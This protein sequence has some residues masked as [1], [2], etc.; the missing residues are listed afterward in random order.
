MPRG[1]AKTVLRLD[2]LGVLSQVVAALQSARLGM[3]SGSASIE[4]V[5]GGVSAAKQPTINLLES[6]RAHYASLGAAQFAQALEIAIATAQAERR[7]QPTVEVVWTGPAV[8]GSHVRQTRQVIQDMINGANSELLLVGYWVA[9]QRDGEGIIADVIS[10]VADAAERGVDVTVVL[11]RGE[12]D[13]GQDNREIFLALWP[14]GTPVPTMLSWEIPEH[15]KY[16]KLHAKVLVVDRVDALVTSANL[17]MHALDKN[18]EMGVRV[19]GPS[20][21]DIAKHFSLLEQRGV[22][23][24]N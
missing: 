7:D 3:D 5:V 14:S 22:L 15:E 20:A 4:D 16:L 19:S 1:L 6:W 18:I 21:R 24:A 9:G 17:T 23:S 2:D 10:L 13:G 12:R 11:D 8:E